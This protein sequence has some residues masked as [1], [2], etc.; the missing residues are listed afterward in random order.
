MRIFFNDFWSGFFDRS[1]AVNEKF[2]LELFELVYSCKI[3]TTFNIDEADILIENTFVKKS[4]INYKKWYH[5]YLFSGESYLNNNYDKYS[6]V[7]YGNRNHKNIINVPLY[8]PYYIS[9]LSEKLITDNIITNINIVPKNDVLVIVS[10]PNGIVRN[11]FINLLENNFNV[12]FAG[13]YKNNIKGKIK[14]NYNSDEFRNYVKNFKFILSMENSEEDTYITEKITH[15]LLA[16]SIPIYWG[17]KRVKDYFNSERFLE[18]KNED[19]FDEVINIMKNMS[20]EE[21]LRKVN[22]KPFTDFGTKYNLKTISNHIKNLLFNKQFPN[23]TKIYFI[24][25]KDYEPIR[26]NNLKLMCDELKLND[27][28]YEFICPTYKHTITDDIMMKYVKSNRIYRLR[29]I[30]IRKS[31]ISLFLNFRAVW[32]N[33][34]KSYKDGIFLILEADVFVLPTIKNFN[35]C[36]NKLINKNWSGINISS[37]GGSKINF[38]KNQS[39]VENLGF[40]NRLSAEHKKLLELNCNE[41]LSDSKDKDVRFMRK[42]HTRCTDS[43]LWSY[44]GCSQMLDRLLTNP[45]YDIPFDYYLIESFENN[46]DIKYYWSDE[47]YFDQA[48]NR[49]LEK[50]TIQQDLN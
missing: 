1:N 49:G 42:Y 2:F 47:T 16:G 23:L 14:H 48:S 50:S 38:I 34:V 17:S 19:D 18:V 41:D 10:N 43:Q 24:C 32:E 45:N 5:T 35:N 28:N 29:N 20:D 3:F 36:V 26:Y 39:Y 6:C 11:K 9:S 31:E 40:R 4:L 25:N 46:M 44:K 12:T 7:L 27:Y 22:L 8:I 33:I 30:P 37:D 21:W 15:G 13:E